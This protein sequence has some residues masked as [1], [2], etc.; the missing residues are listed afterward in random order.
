LVLSVLFAEGAACL[1]GAIA[2]VLSGWPDPNGEVYNPVIFA[3]VGGL[4]L[5]V[6]FM[7]FWGVSATGRWRWTAF[8][9]VAI[10]ILGFS[11]LTIFSIGAFTGIV[12]L[13]LL[14]FSLGKLFSQRSAGPTE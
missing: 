13:L 11:A 9:L 1:A 8:V 7:L 14:G 5:S 12:G 10:L 4:A 3:L 2:V 6:L